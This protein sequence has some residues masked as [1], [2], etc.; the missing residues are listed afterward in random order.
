MLEE[1][2]VFSYSKNASSFL[3][4][5]LLKTAGSN[6]DH[7]DCETGHKN[8]GPQKNVPANVPLG[9][10]AAHVVVT[11]AFHACGVVVQRASVELASHFT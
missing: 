5:K 6:N 4:C 7:S 3:L 1:G 10:A 2:V 9:V 11:E 8:D